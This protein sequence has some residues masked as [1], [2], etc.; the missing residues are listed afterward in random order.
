M[1]NYFL[2]QKIYN[3][4]DRFSE[5]KDESSQFTELKSNAEKHVLKEGQ[6]N[7]DPLDMRELHAIVG[8]LEN[9]T[10]VLKDHRSKQ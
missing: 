5:V 4:Q 6:E 2:Y 3:D 10:E 1:A 7:G 8:A 9:M